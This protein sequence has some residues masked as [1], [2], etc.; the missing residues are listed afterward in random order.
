MPVRADLSL[1]H[2]G[3]G[4]S[5]YTCETCGG[6]MERLTSGGQEPDGNGRWRKSTTQAFTCKRAIERWSERRRE[7]EGELSEKLRAEFGDHPRW[8][9]LPWPAKKV[10]T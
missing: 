10:S 3:I 6:P 1:P 8:V 5:L 4:V 7:L 9:R 2:G